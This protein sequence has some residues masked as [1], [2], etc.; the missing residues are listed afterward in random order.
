M[1]ARKGIRGLIER[2]RLAKRSMSTKTSA[3]GQQMFESSTSDKEMTNH[4]RNHNDSFPPPIGSPSVMA[5][6]SIIGKQRIYFKQMGFDRPEL[7]QIVNQHHFETIET[8]PT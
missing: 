3:K 4:P 1:N 7:V 6:Q 2:R 5:R 8:S